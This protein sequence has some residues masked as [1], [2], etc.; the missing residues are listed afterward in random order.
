MHW[1]YLSRLF[2]NL[3]YPT[4]ECARLDE[5]P[6]KEADFDCAGRLLYRGSAA[7]D[8]LPIF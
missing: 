1:N 8:D 5:H 3:I 2:N 4:G 6:V 7:Y